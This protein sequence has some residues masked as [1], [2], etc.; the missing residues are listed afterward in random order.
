MKLGMMEN[1][2]HRHVSGG[3]NTILVENR[4]LGKRGVYFDRRIAMSHF[5]DR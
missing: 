1:L 2:F 3:R 4:P 5:G